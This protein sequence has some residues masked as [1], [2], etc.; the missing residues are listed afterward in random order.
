MQTLHD[1]MMVTK[2]V[3]YLIAVLFLGAFILLWRFVTQ[4]R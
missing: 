3:E 1:Y 4:K 2:A